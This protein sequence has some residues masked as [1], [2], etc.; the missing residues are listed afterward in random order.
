MTELLQQLIDFIKAASPMV[1]GIYVKQVYVDAAVGVFWGIGVLIASPFLTKFAKYAFNKYEEDKYS[2]WDMW[3]YFACAGAVCGVAIGLVLITTYIKGFIN[4]E[5]YA[6]QNILS[7]LK[8][9]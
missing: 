1:W 6:I 9:N 5:Y 7:Q 4:P 3:A 2:G 8:G